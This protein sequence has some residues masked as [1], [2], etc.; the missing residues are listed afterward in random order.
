[1]LS[2]ILSRA[3]TGNIPL[4]GWG[5]MSCH[6]DVFL[7]MEYAVYV[8]NTDR[9]TLY[10]TSQCGITKALMCTLMGV[11]M[12]NRN[13]VRDFFW[14]TYLTHAHS[15][16]IGSMGDIE[17]H[18]R[19][20][21]GMYPGSQPVPSLLK[22]FYKVDRWVT[23]DMQE[24]C[25]TA[26]CKYKE[27]RKVMLHA[28]VLPEVIMN[29]KGERTYEISLAHGIFRAILQSSGVRQKCPECKDYSSV[30]RTKMVHTISLPR[31]LAVALDSSG[32]LCREEPPM[33]LDICKGRAYQLVGVAIRNSGHYRGNVR[34]GAEWYQ[35]DD[36]GGCPTPAFFRVPSPSYL[37]SASYHRRLLYYSL[38]ADAPLKTPQLRVPSWMPAR[39]GPEGDNVQEEIVE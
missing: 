8:F 26:G 2:D 18:V 36:G 12:P 13:A 32:R 9:G 35:Y 7:L 11:A 19:T 17:T 20:F 6:V 22:I 29:T 25:E 34:I 10:G 1:M 39:G 37:P 14:K 5:R 27:T 23:Y 21:G 3:A 4:W 38:R 15:D 24:A 30:V 33:S 16:P 28:L 31:R